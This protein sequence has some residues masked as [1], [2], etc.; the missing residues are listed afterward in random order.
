M[1]MLL[2][3]RCTVGVMS[4]LKVETESRG[5]IALTAGKYVLR[6]RDDSGWIVVAEAYYGPVWSDIYTA[7]VLK[8]GEENVVYEYIPKG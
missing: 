2:V 3:S 8:H 4:E 1:L 6:L 5:L 7:A